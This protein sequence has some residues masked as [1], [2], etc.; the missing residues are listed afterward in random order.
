MSLSGS[1][2]ILIHNCSGRLVSE[3]DLEGEE[4]VAT[5][6]CSNR[7]GERCDHGIYF[8]TL[9]GSGSSVTE[10]VLLLD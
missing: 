5:W 3:I 1:A 8:I 2:R 9:I 6:N 7:S 4:Q 10:K